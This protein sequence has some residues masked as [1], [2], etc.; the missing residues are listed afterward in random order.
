MKVDFTCRRF[1]VTGEALDAFSE[2]EWSPALHRPH[3]SISIAG[4]LKQQCGLP[5]SMVVQPI[6]SPEQHEDLSKIS[7]PPADEVERCSS[8]FS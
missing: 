8:C 7:V 3:F 1:P 6:A 5:F 4:S 2:C